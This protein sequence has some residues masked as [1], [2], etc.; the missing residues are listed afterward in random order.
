M[1]L[2]FTN[3]VSRFRDCW[4][5]ETLSW[6]RK[7]R[8]RLKFSNSIFFSVKYLSIL[9]RKPRLLTCLKYFWLFTHGVSS[10]IKLCE[11]V[12]TSFQ[13]IYFKALKVKVATLSSLL[14]TLKT[15]YIPRKILLS[16]TLQIPFFISFFKHRFRTDNYDHI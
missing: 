5:N 2:S 14:H 3:S 10:M 8:L 11:K 16:T 12:T 7:R 13:I 4:W 15:A 1:N 6:V 9:F